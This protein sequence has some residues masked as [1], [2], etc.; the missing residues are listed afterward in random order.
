MTYS[1]AVK[2][3]KY[4]GTVY[5]K[6]AYKGDNAAIRFARKHAQKAVFVLVRKQSRHNPADFIYRKG[7]R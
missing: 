5:H 2:R 6:R 1:V 3:S 7:T 4:T